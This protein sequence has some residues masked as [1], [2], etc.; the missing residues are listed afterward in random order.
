MGRA[1]SALRAIGH[2]V[3]RFRDYLAPL[4]VLVVVASA[5]ASDFVVGDVERRV[6]GA[7]GIVLLLAG[8]LIRIAVAGYGVVRRAGVNKR[9]S[10]SRLVTDGL[11][12]HT[13]NPLYV[14]NVMILGGLAALYG[15]RPVLVVG[16]PVL[17]LVIVAIV[18]AEE[19]FLAGRFGGD[20]AAYRRRADRFVPRVRGLRTTLASLP[21]DVRRAVRR[22]YGT[23]FASASTALGLLARR[24]VAL[25]GLSG[26]RPFLFAIAAAWG[27]CALAY[28]TIRW[29]K[30]TKRLET[31]PPAIDHMVWRHDHSG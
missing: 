4:A 9:I 30:K 26:A 14:A 27:I 15:S 16:M 18:T 8:Q 13:R 3:F 20:Y 23:V 12:A 2:L 19:E 25:D 7:V 24:R 28:A 10:A 22:E 21:F 5:R 29:M 6:L 17:A 31:P 1:A 11:Y